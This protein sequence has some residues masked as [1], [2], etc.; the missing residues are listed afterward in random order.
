MGQH[1]F[2][3]IK[4]GLAAVIE[5][6]EECIKQGVQTLF[7]SANLKAEPTGGLSLGA[8]IMDPS[9]FSGRKPLVIVSGGNVDSAVYKS[10]IS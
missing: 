10:I 8:I 6:S 1:N 5:V 2:A 3:I 9:R 4:D 7:H